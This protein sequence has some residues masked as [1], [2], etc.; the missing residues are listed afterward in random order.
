MRATSFT[1]LI[2]RLST[3]L[4]IACS[5]DVGSEVELRAIAKA[6]N[7]SS[8]VDTRL[9]LV[10][11]GQEAWLGTNDNPNL[12]ETDS[13]LQ[14]KM[15]FNGTY[16]LVVENVAESGSDLRVEISVQRKAS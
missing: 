16:H 5:S 6:L 11:P 3:T 14:G 12:G 10:H 2:A 8:D 9:S 4:R 7:P 13:L 1:L 15:P